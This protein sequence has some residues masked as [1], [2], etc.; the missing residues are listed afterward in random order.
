MDASSGMAPSHS[1]TLASEAFVLIAKAASL[2]DHE[3][4]EFLREFGL[5][6]TQYNVLR[7]LRDAGENGAT[8]SQVAERMINR[9]PD[10]TRMLDRLESR[11]WAVRNRSAADRR[12]VQVQ[13]STAGAELLAR[14]DVP[15][16]EWLD[17]RF[18]EFGPEQLRTLSSLLRIVCGDN[19]SSFPS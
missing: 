9:D 7:I 16:S 17:S 19:T 6:P 1:G 5:S 18:S 4:T 2:M 12:V 15:V 13:L 10:I 14:L 3:A 8:C 11:G